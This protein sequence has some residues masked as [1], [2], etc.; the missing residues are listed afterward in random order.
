MRL[1]VPAAINFARPR[2]TPIHGPK[3]SIT[4]RGEPACS[5]VN[6]ETRTERY[7]DAKTPDEEEEEEEEKKS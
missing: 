4:A 3:S 5:R 7:G 1:T 2:G 6:A